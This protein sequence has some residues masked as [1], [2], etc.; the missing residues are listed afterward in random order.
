[1]PTNSPCAS[2]FDVAAVALVDGTVYVE[3][4][5][6]E[7][8]GVDALRVPEDIGPRLLDEPCPQQR[9]RLRGAVADPGAVVVARPRLERRAS[10]IDEDERD[11]GFDSVANFFI[12][13]RNAP[14]PELLPPSAGDGGAHA[15]K[16]L[17]RDRPDIRAHRA[18]DDNLRSL[19]GF[20]REGE[21]ERAAEQARAFEIN[22]PSSV[23]TKLDS[24]SQKGGTAGTL[25]MGL[26]FSLASF[27]CVG[28]FMGTLLAAS[29]QSG[30]VRPLVGMATFATGL[31]LP[32]FLLAI[33]PSY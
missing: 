2:V 15:A 3:D 11:L 8:A 13:Y 7:T 16:A 26:T 9:K 17:D 22:I 1:M 6:H 4:G 24:V 27:A 5:G 33:F 23:L 29:V 30:G 25:V 31:A 20:K 10:R 21:F 14:F 19:A 18:G 32:F 12:A 28:P